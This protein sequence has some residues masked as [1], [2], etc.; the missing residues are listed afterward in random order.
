MKLDL[1][2]FIAEW[3]GN[4]AVVYLTRSH[5]LAIERLKNNYD[6]GFDLFVTILRDNLPTDRVFC[7]QVKAYDGSL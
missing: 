6:Y 4:L 3:G 2:Q 1:E 7:V 5:N